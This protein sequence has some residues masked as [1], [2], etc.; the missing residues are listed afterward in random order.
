MDKKPDQIERDIREYRDQVSSRIVDLR[1]RARDDVHKVRSEARSR[2]SGGVESAKST[3]NSD[4]IKGMMQ[5]HTVSMIAGAVGVGV[6]LGVASEAIGDGGASGSNDSPQKSQSNNN[7]SDAGRGLISMLSSFISPAAS[8]AQQELQDLI[9]EGF[10]TLKEQVRS[11]G[12]ESGI[13]AEPAALKE[14][15]RQEGSESRPGAEAVQ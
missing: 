8:T 13:G 4:S 7:Q 10:A 9:R 12:N 15:V 11:G 2:T 6:L 1:A 14:E 5:D 3:L